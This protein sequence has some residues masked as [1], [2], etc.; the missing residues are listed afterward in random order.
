MLYL[1]LSPCTNLRALRID[2]ELA[3]YPE[4][5]V[6]LRTVSSKH[7]EKL[8]FVPGISRNTSQWDQNDEIFRSFAERLYRLGAAEPLTLVLEL[9]AMEEERVK[10]PDVQHMLPL[11]CEVGIIVKE[12]SGLDG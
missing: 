7:F 10:T 11:F 4:F 2:P 12:Y 3:S 5:D 8:I 9:R 1:D 6:P